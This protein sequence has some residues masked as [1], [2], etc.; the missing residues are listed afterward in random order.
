MLPE[1]EIV[2]VNT[3]F[4]ENIGMAARACANF[5]CK[6]ICLVKPEKKDLLNAIPLATPKG[7]NILKNIRFS[8]SL[9]EAVSCSN[10]VTAP[11]QGLEAGEKPYSVQMKR[12][13]KWSH[14]PI[15]K[16]L[17]SLVRKIEV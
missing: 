4:P 6:N 12:R 1:L 9:S 15:K 13:K 10:I 3:R 2:L 5:G 8:A 11:L 14:I 17:W 16:F 7:L